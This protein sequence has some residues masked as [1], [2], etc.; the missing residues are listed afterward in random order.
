MLCCRATTRR[1]VAMMV[2][3][4]NCEWLS[5][6][7]ENGNVALAFWHFGILAFWDFV[8]SDDSLTFVQEYTSP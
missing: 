4:S 5:G 8:L 7:D 3:L 1:K 6:P 2:D